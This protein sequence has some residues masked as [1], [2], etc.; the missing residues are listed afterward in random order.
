MKQKWYAFV[1]PKTGKKG[2]VDNWKACEKEVS[3]VVGARY[4]S[5]KSREDADEWLRRGAHY[6]EKRVMPEGI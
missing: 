3:G 5:F 1:I 4:Q 2:V 6:H